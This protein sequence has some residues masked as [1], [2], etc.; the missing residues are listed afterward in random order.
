[1]SKGKWYNWVGDPYWDDYC[2][3]A[4][5]FVIVPG[6]LILGALAIGI[7]TGVVEVVS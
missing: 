5:M 7:F 1:M 3:F 2:K 4:L 6:F